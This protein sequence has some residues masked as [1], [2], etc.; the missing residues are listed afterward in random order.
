M[1][2]LSNENVTRK[3]GNEPEMLVVIERRKLEYIVRQ[4]KICI[5]N[6]LGKRILVIAIIS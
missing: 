6:I 5:I 1:E 2:R 4:Q 3:R